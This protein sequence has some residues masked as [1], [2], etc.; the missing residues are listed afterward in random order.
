MNPLKVLGTGAVTCAGLD[1]RQ[2]CAA[3]RAGLTGFQM[4]IFSDPMGGE[5][6]VGRV[7]AR[8]AL[9]S[10]ARGWLVSLAARALNQ[11]LADATSP[12]RGRALF[13]IT[14]ER[15]RAHPALDGVHPEAF[16]ALAVQKS[17]HEFNAASRVLDGGAAAALGSIVFAAET[18]ARGD[19]DEVL[20][21]GV[22]SLLGDGDLAR[23]RAAGRLLGPDNPQG[24]V[25]AE[26][27]AAVRLALRDD[28]GG[29]ATIILGVATTR[30]PDTVAGARFSEGRALLQAFR[31][32]LGGAGE[33]EGKVEFIVSNANGERYVQWEANLARMR[34]FRS[35]R[36]RLPVVLP[37]MA[38]SDL[39][40]ASSLL[41]L[42]ILHDAFAR[43]HAPGRVALIEATSEGGL[44][45]AALV[46]T[47]G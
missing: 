40:S 16:L 17:G 19:A 1:A 39:G 11:A 20:V 29:P 34:G 36:E 37:A 47:A 46:A 9:R 25:P 18:L 6:T 33:L 5:Q 28:A 27:A 21:L 10:N 22:D 41:G 14:L 24:M 4:I 42:L 26:G 31:G 7:P 3:V 44:R 8:S 32:A 23:L 43:G 15:F 13:L 35:W 45:S 2:T 38:V 12:P 30:E